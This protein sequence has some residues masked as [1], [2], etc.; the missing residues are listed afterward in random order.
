MELDA[1]A[2]LL[3]SWEPKLL[4]T[5]EADVF[6][7]EPTYEQRAAIY[8]RAGL[9]AEG[10]KVNLATL[11][12]VAAIE[13]CRREDGKPL[14]HAADLDVLRKGRAGGWLDRIQPVLMGALNPSGEA[15]AENFGGTA[16]AG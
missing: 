10:R 14:F 3:A 7:V 9:T 2:R 6:V 16:S 1:R 13:L 11:V 5:P 4:P 8:E 12:A 15:V